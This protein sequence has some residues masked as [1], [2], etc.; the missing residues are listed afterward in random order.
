MKMKHHIIRF[1][2]SERG[3]DPKI[4]KKSFNILFFS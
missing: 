4:L 2:C 3:K 1:L